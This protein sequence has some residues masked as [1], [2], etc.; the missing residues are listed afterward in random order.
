MTATQR[1][2]PERALVASASPSMVPVVIKQ[3]NPLQT[4]YGQSGEQLVMGGNAVD[5]LGGGRWTCAPTLSFSLHTL[6]FVLLSVRLSHYCKPSLD[7]GFTMRNVSHAQIK[8][9]RQGLLHA[10]KSVSNHAGWF[11]FTSPPRSKVAHVAPL[12]SQ[13][14]PTA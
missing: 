14:V 1:D 6:P 2:R 3:D 8:F 11:P 4:V 12:Q 13:L 9:R 5:C 10:A 7:L